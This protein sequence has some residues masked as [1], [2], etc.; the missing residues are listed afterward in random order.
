VANLCT[1]VV[2]EYGHNLGLGHTPNYPIMVDYTVPPECGGQPDNGNPFLARTLALDGAKAN[3]AHALRE[4]R[5]RT[6]LARA[7]RRPCRRWRIGLARSRGQLAEI[8]GVW[9]R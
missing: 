9:R 4:C 7:S 3:I 1:T 8:E 6:D 2:H 5:I